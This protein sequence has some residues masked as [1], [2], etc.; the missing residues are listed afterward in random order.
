MSIHNSY[1]SRNNTIIYNSSGNTGLNPVTELFFG[2]NQDT[3]VPPGFSRFI[4]DIDLSQLQQKISDGVVYTGSPMTH[5]LKMTNT[6]M[7]NYDLLN[8]TMSD[9]RRRASSSNV[10]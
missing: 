1:F 2:R 6:M 4:F 5:K 7:F 3:L 9:G 10:S 8:G